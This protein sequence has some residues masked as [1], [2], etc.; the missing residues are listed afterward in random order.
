MAN[1]VNR[2][3]KFAAS[4]AESIQKEVDCIIHESKLSY[5]VYIST[6]EI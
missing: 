6:S 4:W 2:F 1:S 5:K 3:I